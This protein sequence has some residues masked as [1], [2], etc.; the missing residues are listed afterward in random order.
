MLSRLQAFSKT[1][2]KKFFPQQRC[3]LATRVSR[4][5]P[6]GMLRIDHHSPRSSAAGC[7]FA[8][9]SSREITHTSGKGKSAR[10]AELMRLLQEVSVPGESSDAVYSG[11]VTQIREKGG[12]V[13]IELH[14]SRHYRTLKREIYSRLKQLSWVTSIDIKMEAAGGPQVALQENS[15]HDQSRCGPR[16]QPQ[17][18]S[19]TSLNGLKHVGSIV[20]VGSCKGG[21]GKSTVAINL[22]FTLARQGFRVGVLDADIYG[23]SLPAMVQPEDSSIYQTKSGLLEPLVFKEVKLMSYGY[24]QQAKGDKVLN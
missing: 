16:K 11:H 19:N 7:F 24:I 4:I 6:Y 20:A 5:Y 15:N 21:V 9:V 17:G 3:L 12:S 18:D 23:P 13:E 14:L 22:A 2:R 1:G 8:F 10:E